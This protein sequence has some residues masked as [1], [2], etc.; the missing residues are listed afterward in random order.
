MSK[1]Y[2]QQVAAY[3]NLI[4]PVYCVWLPSCCYMLI[5]YQ[6]KENLSYGPIKLKMTTNNL[7]WFGKVKSLVLVGHIVARSLSHFRTCYLLIC[8]DAQ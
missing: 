2:Q 1:H 5:H 8:D 4:D 6:D 3:R 7:S